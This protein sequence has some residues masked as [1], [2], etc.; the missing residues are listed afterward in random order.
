VFEVGAIVKR[1]AAGRQ[2]GAAAL[3][4]RHLRSADFV[5]AGAFERGSA[6]REGV[7]VGETAPE[8]RFV[9]SVENS[10][11]AEGEVA[12]PGMEFG[13]LS[14]LSSNPSNGVG[15]GL[16][17]QGPAGE[18]GPRDRRLRDVHVD[19]GSQYSA[20]AAARRSV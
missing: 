7:E 4:H 9:F 19:R 8:S 15:T 2:N 12:Y 3:R 16:S 18:P 6:S 20:V 1:G 10:D 5:R 14:P 11:V 13:V 17:D